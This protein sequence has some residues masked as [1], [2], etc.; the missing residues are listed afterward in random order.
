MWCKTCSSPSSRHF[1]WCHCGM[2]R[3]MPFRCHRYPQW[4]DLPE[5]TVYR[6]VSVVSLMWISLFRDPICGTL[7]YCKKMYLC[8]CVLIRNEHR[9]RTEHHWTCK[10]LFVF[11][12]PIMPTRSN[13]IDYGFPFGNTL[14]CTF[15]DCLYVQWAVIAFP[16]RKITLK[17]KKHH[18]SQFELR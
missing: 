3:H 7:G 13:S 9:N 2:K 15:I 12:C 18:K 8:R 11:L 4:H 10:F 14:L 1:G 6:G 17:L 5:Y 16:L